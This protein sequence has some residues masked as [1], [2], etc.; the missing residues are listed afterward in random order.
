[1]EKDCN[2]RD[3]HSTVQST[4]YTRK[5]VDKKVFHLASSKQKEIEEQEEKKNNIGSIKLRSI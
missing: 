1:M 5:T 2:D 4:E 3:I